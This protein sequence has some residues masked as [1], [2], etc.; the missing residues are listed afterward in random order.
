M[1]VFRDDELTEVTM[2]KRCP[3]LAAACCTCILAEQRC[4]ALQRPAGVD[5]H[6]IWDQ[7]Y[8][9]KA[10]GTVH[11]STPDARDESYNMDKVLSV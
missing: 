1:L 3:S 4:T 7:S 8:R 11:P 6:R 9:N 10:T 2:V 5:T